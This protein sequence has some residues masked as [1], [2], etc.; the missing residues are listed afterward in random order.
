MNKAKIIFLYFFFALAVGCKSKQ[1]SI[2]IEKVKDSTVRNIVLQTNNELIISSL[3]DTI[4]GK[5]KE[6]SQVINTGNSNLKVTSKDN[7][8]KIDV[9]TPKIVYVDR[10][11]SKDVYKDKEIIRYKTNYKAVITLIAIIILMIV[12]PIVP[13]FINTSI[14]RFITWF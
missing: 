13:K 10:V 5:A 8:L 11:I 9:E 7:A 4:T 14:R 1:K 3:C 2:Y 6:F 12:F